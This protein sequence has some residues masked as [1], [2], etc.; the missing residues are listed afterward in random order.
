MA[1]EL[2]EAK[3]K[4][5]EHAQSGFDSA[6]LGPELNVCGHALLLSSEAHITF[7]TSLRRTSYASS[8]CFSFL[9]QQMQLFVFLREFA[10]LQNVQN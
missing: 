5:L 10:K 3:E 8:P 7:W 2:V 6:K 4:L 9:S 1:H